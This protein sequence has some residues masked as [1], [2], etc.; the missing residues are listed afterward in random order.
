M[1]L[2]AA[3]LA[4][5]EGNVEGKIVTGP[6]K[7]GFVPAN[8]NT[9]TGVAGA[10][11]IGGDVFNIRT[12]HPGQ[13]GRRGRA[14]HHEGRFDHADIE[15]PVRNAG[16]GDHRLV[17]QR[18]AFTGVG[19]ARCAE[20]AAV[21]AARVQAEFVRKV[22][23]GFAF[24]AEIGAAHDS[25]RAE[26]GRAAEAGAMGLV[27]VLHEAGIVGL[28]SGAE[29][30]GEAAVTGRE[31]GAAIVEIPHRRIV[32]LFQGRQ[33]GA[34]GGGAIGG[35]GLRVFQHL[36]T[37]GEFGI[38]DAAR[39]RGDVLRDNHGVDGFAVVLLGG[40]RAGG[41]H[42]DDGHARHQCPDFHYP[43]SFV[44]SH[45]ILRAAAIAGGHN[46]KM[47]VP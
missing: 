42:G 15:V 36:E 12:F 34:V 4:A 22:G 6:Q 33:A 26:V 27:L 32:A 10:K 25:T 7:I 3:G 11:G 35:T 14:F 28:E 40:L 23:I 46:R 21:G 17:Q 45:A 43:Q 9:T 20:A 16:I 18:I 19:H 47:I 8:F 29:G 44:E 31:G 24:D 2:G 1:V 41:G 37:G 39:S 38:G 30:E 5:R 13:V